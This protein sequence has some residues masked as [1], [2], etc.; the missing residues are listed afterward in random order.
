MCLRH[1]LTWWQIVLV[2]TCGTMLIGGERSGEF[3]TCKIFGGGGGDGSL[4][5]SNTGQKYSFG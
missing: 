3:C 4:I 1:E 5:G 2:G